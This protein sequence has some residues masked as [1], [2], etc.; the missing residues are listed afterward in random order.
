VLALRCGESQAA[1]VRA[2][3]HLH[4]LRSESG[5]GCERG[6]QPGRASPHCQ[7]RGPARSGRAVSCSSGVSDAGEAGSRQTPTPSGD[8]A[9]AFQAPGPGEATRPLPSLGW[10][11]SGSGNP[12]LPTMAVARAVS[13]KPPR[14]AVLGRVVWVCS[15]RK[16]GHLRH[17]AGHLRH[18]ETWCTG[19][20]LVWETVVVLR[21]LPKRVMRR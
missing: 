15:V 6:P 1:P 20:G 12:C 19:A 8:G 3:V 7:V 18:R 5:P 11:G 9:A 21:L 16:A 14:V 13:P 10:Q 2:R 4:H 17:R